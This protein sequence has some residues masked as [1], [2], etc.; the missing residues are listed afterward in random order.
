MT[1]G[2]RSGTKRWIV[3]GLMAV[4]FASHA[5]A[6]D[7]TAEREARWKDVA[8]DIFGERPLEDGS[9]MLKLIVPD[10][11]MDAG[12]VPVAVE[13]SGDRHIVAVSV[14]VDNNPSP[15]AGTFRFGPAFAQGT[16]K[17]RV[18]VNEYTLMHA[19]AETDDGKLY[20]V[21][22]YVKAAGGCSA[23]SAS[24]SND[25]LA[26]LGKMQLRR[27][28]SLD[29]NSIPAQ[30]MISHPNYSGMQQ[31]AAGD[32][33]PARYLEHVSVS[34]GGTKAFDLDTG[35]SLSEDPAISFTYLAK[36]DG[37]I[38]VKAKDSAD[39]VFSQHFN[40]LK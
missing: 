6:A 29:P 30:L 14:V 2:T 39:A 1:S 3:A 18:R 33:T 34:V 25:I 27:E 12:L 17:M 23:P 8:S 15:L 32:Y 19:V 5:A 7:E 11:A 16:L 4:A 36:G 22:R 24:M 28:R 38:D 10:R 26:R 9:D 21:A 13:L 40:A 31:N 35:I 37:D 20:A